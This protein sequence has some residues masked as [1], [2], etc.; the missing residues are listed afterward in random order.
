MVVFI[1]VLCDC[2]WQDALLDSRTLSILTSYLA[3]GVEAGVRLS[4]FLDFLVFRRREPED[5]DELHSNQNE[6]SSSWHTNEQTN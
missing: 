3:A 5:H 2:D 4:L 1:C 6:K